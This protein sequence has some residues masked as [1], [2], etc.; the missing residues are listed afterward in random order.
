MKTVDA[1]AE[2]QQQ[3]VAHQIGPADS[4]DPCEGQWQV[5]GFC[6]GSKRTYQSTLEMMPVK[7]L[8]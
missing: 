4:S 2:Q 1:V 3:L 6:A 5:D 8:N 7:M